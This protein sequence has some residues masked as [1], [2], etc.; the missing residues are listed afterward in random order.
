MVHCTHNV[1]TAAPLSQIAGSVN[2]IGAKVGKKHT[3]GRFWA[4]IGDG[5]TPRGVYGITVKT[6]FDTEGSSGCGGQ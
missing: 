6:G 4:Q 2:T 1:R 5:S 3:G